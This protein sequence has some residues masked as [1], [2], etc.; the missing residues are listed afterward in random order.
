MK[1]KN[2]SKNQRLKSAKEWV[3]VYPGQNIVQGY[4]KKYGVDKLCAIYEL[5]LIGIAVSD[6]YEKQL[7]Q[8]I[9]ALNHQ[10][11]LQ[12]KESELS[13]E[14]N[15]DFAAIIGYTSGGAPYGITHDEWKE[16]NNN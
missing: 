8:S 12:K 10:R 2:S 9:E 5:R 16:I 15:E 3:K 4:S 11:K 1:T 7:R 6:E 13:W 14:S